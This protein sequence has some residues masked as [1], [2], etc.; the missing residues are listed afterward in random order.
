MSQFVYVDSRINRCFRQSSSL[1]FLYH[2]SN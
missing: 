1:L 2:S